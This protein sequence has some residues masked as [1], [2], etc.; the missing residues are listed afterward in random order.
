MKITVAMTCYNSIKFIEEAIKS[1]VDQSYKNWE[2]IIVDD[3]SKDNT[4]KVVSECVRKHKIEEKVKILKHDRNYGYGRSLRDS[5]AGGDGDLIAIID[6]DDALADVD[7]F[8]IMVEAHIDNPKASLCYSTYHGCLNTLKK[9]KVRNIKLI[10]KGET[11]LS[12]LMKRNKRAR[13][14]HLKVF[15]RRLYDQTEGVNPTLIRSVDRDLVLKLEE[16]GKLEFIPKPLYIRRRHSQ[17]LTSIFYRQSLAYRKKVRSDKIQFIKD[18]LKRRGLL[19]S[20]SYLKF[21]SARE[22]KLMGKK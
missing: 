16:V 10:P 14:S 6:S 3:Y 21:L 17:G 15:K 5:I 13:V 2:L 19:A 7:A 20:G 11:Y 9:G 1:I 8:K 22:R 4:L 12:C 18:A